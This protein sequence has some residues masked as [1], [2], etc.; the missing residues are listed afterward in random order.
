MDTSQA[1]VNPSTS[2]PSREKGISVGLCRQFGGKVNRL[3]CQSEMKTTSINCICIT[4]FLVLFSETW[5]LDGRWGGKTSASWDRQ[6]MSRWGN[7]TI[8]AKTLSFIWNS[9]GETA[10]CYFRAT[11]ANNF[12]L[13]ANYYWTQ[14]R[15]TEKHLIS[16]LTVLPCSHEHFSHMAMERGQNKQCMT[17]HSNLP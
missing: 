1:V 17:D 8:T 14:H 15:A 5:Y 3:K 10:Q 2:S 11:A 4:N 7:E 9:R 13:P 16:N 12:K 6:G